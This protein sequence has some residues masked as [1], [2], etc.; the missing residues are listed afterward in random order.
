MLDSSLIDAKYFV[1]VETFSRSILSQISSF[2]DSGDGLQILL[3]VFLG[4]N[5]GLRKQQFK[6]SQVGSQFKL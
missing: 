2:V 3:T 1:L 6:P 5:N 4:E